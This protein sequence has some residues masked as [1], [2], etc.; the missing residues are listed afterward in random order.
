MFHLGRVSSSVLY[1]NN[2]YYNITNLKLILMYC[3]DYNLYS[4]IMNNYLENL[5]KNIPDLKEKDIDALS[6]KIPVKKIPKGSILIR[7]GD[8][9]EKCYYV[10]EGCIR[11]YK[12]DKDG[13][14]KTTRFYFSKDTVAVFNQEDIK[15]P[16]SF[17]WECATD[18]ILL[19]GDLSIELDIL[20]KYPQ[21]EGFIRGILESNIDKIQDDFSFYVESTPQERVEK[22]LDKH[23]ELF[24]YAPQYQ[25]ASY[26]GITPESLSRIK[27][28]L[29]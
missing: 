18:S 26:L 11:E 15:L 10:F 4:F 19:V 28:R 14:E 29:L 12:V 6:K 20:K 21:I 25:I 23:P 24:D 5:L 2:R 7:Q 13:N 27:K 16:S 3:L 17:F 9:H 22:L 1:S 8:I